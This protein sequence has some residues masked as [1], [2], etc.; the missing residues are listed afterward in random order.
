MLVAVGSKQ[1]KPDMSSTAFK[2]MSSLS[3]ETLEITF[4]D[5]E[6]EQ[7]HTIELFLTLITCGHL[8]GYEAKKF[9]IPELVRIVR[10]LQKYGCHP[11]LSI[12]ILDLKVKL[13]EGELGSLTVFVLG[14]IND[15][16]D[17]C[18]AAL[19]QGKRRV[20]GGNTG[21]ETNPLKNGTKGGWGLDPS[22]FPREVWGIVPPNHLWALTRAVREVAPRSDGDISTHKK[23]RLCDRFCELM[24][25]V[26]RTSPFSSTMTD[27]KATSAN[28]N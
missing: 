8:L 21:P 14:A 16:L 20:W 27:L 26:E 23:Q 11:A 10:F 3:N 17:I 28:S 7:K 19:L 24:A 25:A 18:K 12:L 13:Y 22:T 2:D 5:D 6:L 15:D 9:S 4:T 1:S